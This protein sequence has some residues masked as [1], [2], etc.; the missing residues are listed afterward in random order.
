MRINAIIHLPE[1]NKNF[2]CT[3]RRFY[4][5][6]TI[7][8]MIGNIKKKKP[9][10]YILFYQIKIYQSLSKAVKQASISSKLKSSDE[11]IDNFSIIY[12]EKKWE[13][14]HHKYYE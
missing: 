9:L 10:N 3:T 2:K 11:H 1:K 12:K 8:L 6:I 5:H 4:T 13:K 7:Q 14:N